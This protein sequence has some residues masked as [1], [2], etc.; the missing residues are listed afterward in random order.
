MEITDKVTERQVKEFLGEQADKWSDKGVKFLKLRLCGTKWRVATHN[1]LTHYT[2][3]TFEELVPEEVNKEVASVFGMTKAEQERLI[4]IGL[5]RPAQKSKTSGWQEKQSSLLKI[6]EDLLANQDKLDEKERDRLNKSLA[7][8]HASE[9]LF[10]LF[11]PMREEREAEAKKKAEEAAKKKEEV[12]GQRQESKAKIGKQE[13]AKPEA[14]PE[15]KEDVAEVVAQQQEDV[16][17]EPEAAPE[18]KEDVKQEE[19]KP[20]ANKG[21]RTR[22]RKK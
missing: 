16:K 22:N 5:G 11:D 7:Q 19:T 21:K 13:E 20:A 1:A 12:K 14:A 3:G 15:V 18:V 2:E 9:S 6:D 10:A 4:I 8:R 17:E